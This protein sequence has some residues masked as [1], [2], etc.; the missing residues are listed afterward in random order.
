MFFYRDASLGA[1]S[2]LSNLRDPKP[3]RMPS[4]KKPDIEC[5]KLKAKDEGRK[6]KEKPEYSQNPKVK[7]Y[8]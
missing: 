7:K 4:G 5:R 6:A 1:R 3:D 2:N 8:M